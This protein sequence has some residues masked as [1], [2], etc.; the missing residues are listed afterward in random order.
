MR[1]D[2]QA[3]AVLVRR[4][5]GQVYGLMLRLTGSPDEAAELAQDTFL[6]AYEHIGMLGSGQRF[7]SW[8]YALGLNLG[9]DRLR[10]KGRSPVQANQEYVERWATLAPGPEDILGAACAGAALARSLGRLETQE[11][12]MLILRYRDEMPFAEL[13]LIFGLS[14]GAAKMRV[15]RSLDRLRQIMEEDEDAR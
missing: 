15:R 1:G 10:R 9:R 2:Q 13:A 6:R 14:G 3:F 8:L 4:Y 5:Q 12:E 11:R 7:F